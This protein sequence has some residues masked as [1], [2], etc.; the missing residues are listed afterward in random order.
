MFFFHLKDFNFKNKRV[1][2]RVD[3]NVPIDHRGR[4][5]DI[6][7]IELSLPTLKY[8]LKQNPQQLVIL[9]HWGR[10]QGKVVRVLKTDA[11][12]RILEKQLKKK[13][14]KVSDFMYPLPGAPIIML[15][16]LRF[17]KGEEE[18]IPSFA[19]ALAQNGDV[20]VNEA[21]SASHDAHASIVGIPHY[22]PSCA[23]LSLE[24][25]IECIRS[26][27]KKPKRPFVAI[28]GGA[29]ITTKIHLM[30]HLLS[31]V[32]KLLIGGMLAF[33][34]IVAKGNMHHTSVTEI[35]DPD[36]ESIRAAKSILRNKRL[37]HKIVLA[38]DFIESFDIGKKTIAQFKKEI[39]GAKTI[40]WNGPLGKFE[41]PKYRRGTRAIAQAITASK[42]LSIVGGGDTAHGLKMMKLSSGITHLSTGGGASVVLFEGR[43]LKGMSALE[44]N[45]RKFK[46]EI[47]NEEILSH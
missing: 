21:F 9:T 28:L 41:D 32:D 38:E 22:I 5:T 24:N 27:L 23:G 17:W 4:I 31:K 1:L 29:K 30:K 40:V 39:T 35:P 25:E 16:N 3:Y 34:F 13:V 7:R 6:E 12:A 19:R 47:K 43:T 18:N 46:K 10:P 26:A 33:P 2:V 11:L 14:K 20:F 37:A 8:I 42:A 45:Y 44:Q 15:E 36:N